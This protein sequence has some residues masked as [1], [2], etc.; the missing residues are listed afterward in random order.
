MLPRTWRQ[1]SL[2]TKSMDTYILRGDRM[3]RRNPYQTPTAQPNR[4][5]LRQLQRIPFNQHAICDHRGEK[6]EILFYYFLGENMLSVNLSMKSFLT[7]FL[8]RS[9]CLN[10]QCRYRIMIHITN[11]FRHLYEHCRQMGRKYT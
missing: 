4:S 6:L 2:L 10:H 1:R 7:T 8:M 9:A 11:L 5:G 3:C